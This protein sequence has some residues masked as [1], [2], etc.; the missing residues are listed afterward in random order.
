MKLSE[1][2]EVIDTHITL[3]ISGLKEKYATKSDISETR[4][5]FEV[6]KVVVCKGIL[7]VQLV[8]TKN[9]ATIDDPGYSFE[10]GN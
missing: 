4:M 3:E 2:L 5:N 9:V 7:I 10:V 1:L 6:T 8:E